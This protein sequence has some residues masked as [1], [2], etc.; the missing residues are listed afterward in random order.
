MK[1]M[2]NPPKN[3]ANESAAK[4]DDEAVGGSHDPVEEASMD[5]FPASDRPGWVSGREEPAPGKRKQSA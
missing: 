1:W 2:T 3:E 4:G 5:S